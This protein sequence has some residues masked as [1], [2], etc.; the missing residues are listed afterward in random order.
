MAESRY[1]L[2]VFPRPAH[3]GR[4][5]RQLGFT[6]FKRPAPSDQA[7][8]LA[9]QFQRLQD[10]LER[11][12]LALQDG[13]LG[14]QPEQVLVLETIGPVDRFVNAVRKIPGLEWLA[15]G[16]VRDIKPEHGFSV[17]NNPD[18]NLTGQLFLVMTDLRALGELRRLF[19]RWEADSNVRFPHGLAPFKT[20]FQHLRR[21]RPWDVRDRLRETGVIE[22][23]AFRLESEPE[24]IPF[25]IEL[26]HRKSRDR[27]RD[28]ERRIRFELES[29]GG[30]LV[31][32]CTIADIAYH[33]ILGCLP[34][35]QVQQLIDGQHSGT[36]DIRLLACDE[37]MYVRPI[38]QCAVGELAR[39]SHNSA[40]RR[41]GCH[42]KGKGR[43][44]WEDLQ[45][46]G[47]EEGRRDARGVRVGG[48]RGPIFGRRR[49][50]VHEAA[51]GRVSAGDR[52]AAARSG[53][54][55]RPARTRGGEGGSSPLRPSR[56]GP[57][58]ARA[59]RS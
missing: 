37:I 22:D 49:H 54:G 33:G 11:K 13:P 17:E 32:Q 50:S 41:L 12:R 30:S 52:A 39:I 58:P 34:R 42:E 46:A 28:A 36:S 8:R 4:A 55:C 48:V 44:R 51:R 5:K 14:I 2:L 10:V 57:R 53:A 16:E 38:G 3:V 59:L 7:T 47:R 15:D 26:W 9:P 19:D 40:E 18:K 27:R 43:L 23:W 45:V 21:I 24:F 35:G 29:L 31:Q 1:P 25:E 20:A 56:A 6:R